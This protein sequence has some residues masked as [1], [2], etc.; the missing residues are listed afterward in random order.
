MNYELDRLGK[1]TVVG[2]LSLHLS[3]ETVEEMMLNK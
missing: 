1:S 3:G 2:A